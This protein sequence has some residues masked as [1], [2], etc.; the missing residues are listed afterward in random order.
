MQQRLRATRSPPSIAVG[1]EEEEI[2]PNRQ[3][4]QARRSFHRTLR[5]QYRFSTRNPDENVLHRQHGNLPQLTSPNAVPEIPL[6][7]FQDYGALRD[8]VLRPELRTLLI[9]FSTRQ[10]P[11]SWGSP[12]IV[13]RQ[14]AIVNFLRTS[15]S[16][17]PA[18]TNDCGTVPSAGKWKASPP[19]VM[20]PL[21]KSTSISSLGK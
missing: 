21:V 5:R 11:C 6:F 10:H 19:H 7:A 14:S 20:M 8:R 16:T 15:F 12:K 3:A 9:A 17:P 13:N 18:I 2:S 1:R 4:A